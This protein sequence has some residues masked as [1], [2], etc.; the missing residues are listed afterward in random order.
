[1]AKYQSLVQTIK[2]HNTPVDLSEVTDQEIKAVKKLS[3]DME[4]I[5]KDYFKIAKMGDKTLQLA[6]FNKQ[7]ETILKAQQ[8]ILKIIG[9]M[10]TMKSMSDRAKK[11]EEVI[12]ERIDFHK[13][14]P[15]EKKGSDFDRKLEINGYKK[16]VKEIEKLNKFHEKFQYNNR[17]AGPHKIFDALQQ[18]ERV[19]YDMIA[20]IERG[21]WDGKVTLED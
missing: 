1:M 8:E 2:E 15:A 11:N 13:K 21:K 5:K 3:K 17:A 16:M 14:S 9:D 19:C 6:G 7:Y 20:E 4:K 18:V 10:T 12:S